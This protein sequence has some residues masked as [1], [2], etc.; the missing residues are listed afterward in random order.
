MR[1][2]CRCRARPS[3][4][5]GAGLYLGLAPGS[6]FTAQLAV[7][8]ALLQPSRLAHPAR[9]FRAARAR[10]SPRCCSRCWP[11]RRSSTTRSSSRRKTTTASPRSCTARNPSGPTCWSTSTDGL[12]PSADFGL[13]LG[14]D[15]EQVTIWFDRQIDA[16][17]IDAPFG[18]AGY[19]LDVRAATGAS[20]GLALALPRHRQPR[21]RGNI[22]GR[23]R[24]RARRRNGSGPARPDPAGRLV[25]A[26]LLRPVA[27]DIDGVHR[28]DRPRAAP[29]RQRPVPPASP[30]PRWA[31]RMS[32]LRYGRSY[33]SRVRMMDLS[34]GGP[35]ST[36][37]PVNPAPAPTPTIPLQHSMP[38]TPATVT[39]LDPTAAPAAP[40]AQLPDRPPPAQ[41]PGRRVRRYPQRGRRTARRPSQRRRRRSGSG[42]ARRGAASDR[43][44]D[45]P[46][47]QRHLDLRRRR[48]P[49]PSP[50][51]GDA[52]RYH[53]YLAAAAARRRLP[54]RSRRLSPSRNRQAGC[55]CCRGRARSAWCSAPP[56]PPTPSWL[57]GVEPSAIASRQAGR[58]DHRRLR[59]RRARAVQ[60]AQPAADRTWMPARPSSR[61]PCRAAGADRPDR[62]RQLG[63]RQP[64]GQRP[65]AAGFV[66]RLRPAGEQGHVVARRRCAAR[67]HPER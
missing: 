16:N 60:P 47:R 22:A 37:D 67:S 32:P 64:A 59:G 21:A 58:A 35:L 20:F 29:Q 41:L 36:D 11:R 52:H 13:R 7:N 48:R 30:T 62:H 27:G 28:P 15:D 55:A 8:P 23:L 9:R 63:R 49:A 38:F 26:Q 51:F 65:L 57:L 44:A 61:Q 56:P 25:A 45:S 42:A 39:N 4:R 43:G 19:R 12:P 3:S 24:R 10:C 1:S 50:Y 6:D 40:Q 53:R 2:P 66:S 5:T 31:T 46:A 34:R 14:W 17:Q 18:T 54:G 33:D